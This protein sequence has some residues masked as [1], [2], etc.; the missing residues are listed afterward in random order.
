[1]SVTKPGAATGSGYGAMDKI[2]HWL[3]VALLA[4]QYVIGW[5]MPDIHRGTKPEGLIAWHLWFGALLIIVIVIRIVW[6]LTHPVPLLSDGTPAWQNLLARLTHGL[7]YLTLV[8][9]LGLGWANASARGYSVSLFGLIPLPPIMPEGSRPGMAAGDIHSF[10]GWC[11]LA[12][13]GLH[14]LAALYHYLILR[15]RVLQRMLPH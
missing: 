13:I 8:V 9:V 5:T 12:L 15:D 4:I 11:L 3:I 7:L 1:M 6:R 14:L 10:L 2:L